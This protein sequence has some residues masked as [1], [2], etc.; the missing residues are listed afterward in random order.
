MPGL[1]FDRLIDVVHATREKVEPPSWADISRTRRR[2]IAAKQILKKRKKVFRGL[3]GTYRWDVKV[4]RH[5]QAEAVGAFNVEQTAVKDMFVKANVPM[6]MLRAKYAFDLT[7]EELNA[8]EEQIVDVIKARRIDAFSDA[9]DRIEEYFWA[10]ALDPTDEITPW[11]LAMSLVPHPGP[12]TPPG[13][14]G[15]NP[16]SWTTKQ[17]LNAS[18][19]TRWRN[20]TAGW[21]EMAA[22][23]PGFIFRLNEAID[24]TNFQAPYPYPNATPEEDDYVFVA[25]YDLRQQIN[26]YLRAQ[27]DNLGRDTRNYFGDPMVNGT[28]VQWVEELDDNPT[29]PFLGINYSVFNVLQA[30]KWDMKEI[31]PRPAPMQPTVVEVYIYKMYNIVNRDPS[32]SFVLNYY[33]NLSA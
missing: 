3:G 16:G 28:P 15:G 26:Q 12:T 20:W 18:L 8:G 30:P 25:P 32:R 5:Q 29:M 14:N 17:G 33:A 6:R 1:S 2:Y 10:P 31:G 27:N 24:R 7:E 23:E 9:I 22:T 13:F 4:E 11:P 19:Y 21:A